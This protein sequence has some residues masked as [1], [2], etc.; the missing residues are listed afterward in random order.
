MPL[1]WMLC[2]R[3]GIYYTACECAVPRYVPRGKRFGR[4]PR[5]RRRTRWVLIGLWERELPLC[6]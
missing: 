1:W 4:C 5:C 3:S 2:L 6:A